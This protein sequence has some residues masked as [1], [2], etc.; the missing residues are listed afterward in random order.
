MEHTFRRFSRVFI[1]VILMIITVLPHY[2]YAKEQAIKEELTGW[3]FEKNDWI[4]INVAENSLQFVREDYSDLS[5]KVRIGSGKDN[6]KKMNYL[7]FSY[8]PKTPEKVWEIRSKHQQKWYNVFGSK[9]SKEQLFLRLYEVKG[10][11]RVWSHY[12][13]HTTPEI[14]TIYTQDAGYGSWGCVL[15]RYTLLKQIEDLFELNEETL[16]VVTT[17]QGSAEIISLLKAF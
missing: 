1:A 9:E 7:G 14:E 17:S 12:G 3:E 2:S 16:R 5:E 11:K 8:D 4:I 10:E 13:I 15:A 6:G